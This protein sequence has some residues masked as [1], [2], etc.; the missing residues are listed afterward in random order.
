MIANGLKYSQLPK[1]VHESGAWSRMTDRGLRIYGVLLFYMNSESGTCWPSE[2]TL[3]KTAGRSERWVRDALRDLE[4]AGWIKIV[5]EGRGNI[6]HIARINPEHRQEPA[7]IEG[8]IPANLRSDTGTPETATPASPC[9]PIRMNESINKISQQEPTD[10]DNNLIGKA[11]ELLAAHQDKT[12]LKADDIPGLVEDL[13]NLWSSGRTAQ[14]TSETTRRELWL[15]LLWA[16]NLT[17]IKQAIADNKRLMSPLALA[18]RLTEKPNA[19]RPPRQP[20]PIGADITERK[21]A[22]PPPPKTHFHQEYQDHLKVHK[23]IE[24]RKLSEPKVVVR[25]SLSVAETEKRKKQLI[26]SVKAG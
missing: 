19:K 18:D 15:A 17:D 11:K 10:A 12:A 9:A 25:P 23:P 7:G 4:A 1:W 16:Y 5:R 24:K 21:V 3:A 14:P 20:A 26:E 6:Y 2:A 13:E 8:T 22:K